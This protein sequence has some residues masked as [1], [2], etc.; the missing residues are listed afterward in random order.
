MPQD[1]KPGIKVIS[2]KTTHLNYEIQVHLMQNYLHF[3]PQVTFECPDS[4]SSDKEIK[5]VLLKVLL[6]SN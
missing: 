3:S 1:D 6:N 5:K 4:T 2:F